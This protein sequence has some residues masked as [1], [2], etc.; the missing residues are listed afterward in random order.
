MLPKMYMNSD[1]LS[2]LQGTF[3]RTRLLES[4]TDTP[5]CRS[6]LYTVGRRGMQTHI[7]YHSLEGA[8]VKHKTLE[9]LISLDPPTSLISAKLS[10]SNPISSQLSAFVR[11]S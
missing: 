4:S 11:A 9:C 1:F 6:F 2:A 7:Q 3:Q 5:G 10:Y 8:S